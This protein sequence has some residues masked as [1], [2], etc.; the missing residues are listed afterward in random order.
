MAEAALPPVMR[1]PDVVAATPN[2]RSLVV[3]VP[4]CV[5]S[6]CLI[7]PLELGG[8]PE[9]NGTEL[10]SP[11]CLTGRLSGR[12]GILRPENRRQPDDG[13]RSV[14]RQYSPCGAASFDHLLTLCLVLA[15]SSAIAGYCGGARTLRKH[16]ANDLLAVA[17][18]P[19]RAARAR[20]RIFIRSAPLRGLGFRAVGEPP[21]MA[22]RA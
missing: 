11:R 4:S 22:R 15:S 6:S 18:S 19:S 5:L 7:A 17:L 1:A 16:A 14:S 12:V 21:F 10:R 9:R 2:F 13:G 8:T 3:F 20:R